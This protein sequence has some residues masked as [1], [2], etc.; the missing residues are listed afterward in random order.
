MVI[1]AAMPN[2]VVMDIARRI[3]IMLFEDMKLLPLTAVKMAKHSPKVITAAQ[4]RR[5]RVTVLF[6]FTASAVMVVSSLFYCRARARAQALAALPPT[7][8]VMI[9]SSLVSFVT[10]SAMTLPSYITYTRSVMDSISEFSQ[11]A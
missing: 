4:S 10:S 1:V 8:Y 7:A 3:L 2:T 5:K 6:F 9:S 11:V